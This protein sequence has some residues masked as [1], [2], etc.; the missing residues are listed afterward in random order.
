MGMVENETFIKRYLIRCPK[1]GHEFYPWNALMVT[2]DK[3]DWKEFLYC[4]NCQHFGNK[5]DFKIG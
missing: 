5:D 2:S 4:P 3:T 1:C